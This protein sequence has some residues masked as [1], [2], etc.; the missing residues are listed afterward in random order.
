QGGYRTQQDVPPASCGHPVSIDPVDEQSDPKL[1]D[2]IESLYAAPGTITDSGWV[3]TVPGWTPVAQIYGYDDGIL[4]VPALWGGM[5]EA[6]VGATVCRYGQSSG[7]PWCGTVDAKG[8][9]FGSYG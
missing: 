3:Q 6:P 4:T 9:S 8:V 2:T 7:G 1:G 5:L